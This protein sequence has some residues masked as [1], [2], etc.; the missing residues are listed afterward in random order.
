[1]QKFEII[2]E[3]AL[4]QALNGNGIVNLLINLTDQ[5]HKKYLVLV[6]RGL[7]NLKVLNVLVFMFGIEF[8]LAKGHILVDLVY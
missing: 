5:S 2:L 4:D 3:L 8:D 6:E 7:K 1:L